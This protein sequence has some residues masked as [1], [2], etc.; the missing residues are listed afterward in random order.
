MTVTGEQPPA[1]PSGY[2][3]SRHS[4]APLG[5][6]CAGGVPQGPGTRST[7]PGEAEASPAR[8]SE[9]YENSTLQPRAGRGA[10]VT[11]QPAPED[12]HLQGVPPVEHVHGGRAN[13]EGNVHPA[14][15]S[16]CSQVVK[17]MHHTTSD[18]K[19]TVNKCK[20]LLKQCSRKS[21]ILSPE[22]CTVKHMLLVTNDRIKCR[23][24]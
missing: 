21:D 15:K 11:R 7:T 24:Q 22:K 10:K 20:G 12:L 13:S 9:R 16:G 8:G 18:A 14:G 17:N 5:R 6:R 23:R 19:Y 3:T 2:Y 1:V 4:G